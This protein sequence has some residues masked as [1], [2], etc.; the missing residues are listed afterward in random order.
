[1]K[2]AYKLYINYVD[3]SFLNKI[4]VGQLASTIKC[5][6]CNNESVCWDTF[7][8][9]SLSLPEGHNDCTLKECLKRYTRDETLDDKDSLPTCSQCN[10][11]RKS[12]KSLSI[13]R[14]PLVLIIQLKKFTND[15]QKISKNVKINEMIAINSFKYYLYACICHKRRL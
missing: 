10:Q 6:H 5:T 14:C 13:I 7:W 9:I 8:D 3:D 11:Q 1:M 12:I 15:G 2:E 4:F